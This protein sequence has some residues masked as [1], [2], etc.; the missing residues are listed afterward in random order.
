MASAVNG[1]SK[2]SSGFADDPRLTRL[3]GLSGSGLFNSYHI[4][5]RDMDKKKLM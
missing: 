2:E 1:F 5:G 4:H 3:A